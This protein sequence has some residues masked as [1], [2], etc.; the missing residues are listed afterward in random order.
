MSSIE[1]AFDQQG[2]WYGLNFY[3]DAE[4]RDPSR[5]VVSLYFDEVDID[6]THE[7]PFFGLDFG[8]DSEEAADL[9]LQLPQGA[10]EALHALLGE[11]LARPK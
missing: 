3:T 9:T 8:K 11:W 1:K 6:G 10:I 2:R 5:T 7:P 4:L